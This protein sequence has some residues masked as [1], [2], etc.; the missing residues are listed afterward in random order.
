M[1]TRSLLRYT[2]L[3]GVILMVIG[4]ALHF[5]GTMEARLGPLD[6][7]FRMK[8]A[9]Q[10]ETRIIL[11][12]MG[13]VIAKTHRL[14]VNLSIQL[15]RVDPT[16]LNTD[17]SSYD[18][19][20]N[21]FYDLLPGFRRLILLFVLRL[22]AIGVG[23]ALLAGLAVW[24]WKDWR[25]WGISALLGLILTGSVLWGVGTRYNVKAFETPRYEGMLET[26]P[27][28]LDLL[29]N[30]LSQ[31]DTLSR[32]LEAVAGNLNRMFSQV[33]QLAPLAKAD[34]EIKVVHVSDIHNNPAAYEFLA[35][36]VKGF[37]ADLILDTGDITDFGTPLEARLAERLAKLEVPYVF[38]PGNH[39]SPQVVSYL[40][41]IPGL[42]VLDGRVKTIKGLTILG[43][44]DPA[45]RNG[46]LMAPQEELEASADEIR[47][48]WQ[49]LSIAPDIVAV[50]NR[51]TA[52]HLL[53]KAQVLLHG[54]DHQAK[55][56]QS[57]TSWIIDAG[58]TG[59]AGMRGLEN[60]SK[61]GDPYSLALLRYDPAPEGSGKTYQ[62]TAV[63]LIKIYGMN[64]RF[65]LERKVLKGGDG[66]KTVSG[67]LALPRTPRGRHGDRQPSAAQ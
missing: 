26:A 23:A 7:V 24:G 25:R 31:I 50:H 65:V 22:L 63:D 61:E 44:G 1:K 37:G 59:A 48:I 40:R 67:D 62:L 9:S 21:Y 52:K 33:D 42:T 13:E 39:D 2:L 14:P 58:S 54:H 57:G 18:Q 46:E 47:E 30:G 27:W 43:L 51:K 35:R 28:L 29:D 8:W 10:G 64:G 45:S 49:S 38:V 5:L 41:K 20:A 6:L 66:D 12:P 56:Y 19:P 53:G 16:L 34:G 55:I 15:N 17:F 11:P 3:Y 4:A 32:R 60:R 36:V